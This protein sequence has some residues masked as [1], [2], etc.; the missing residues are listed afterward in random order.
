RRTAGRAA[1][2]GCVARGPSTACAVACRRVRP[3]LACRYV[4]SGLPES[5]TRLHTRMR[6][7]RDLQGFADEDRV[8]V[9]RGAAAR[10]AERDALP[11]FLVALPCA[12]GDVAERAGGEQFQDRH[13][14]SPTWAMLPACLRAGDP[15]V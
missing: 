10:V 5:A 1:T 15:V 3:R 9:R 11:V 2:A 12:V 8:A 7:W 14:V 6:R 4:F 13:G